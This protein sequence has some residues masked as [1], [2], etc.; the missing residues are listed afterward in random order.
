[1]RVLVDTSVWVDFFNGYPSQ[2]AETLA[3]L[4]RD[5]EDIVT[6][7]LV[8]A[9]LLQGFRDES[10]VRRVR[11]HLLDMDWLS[12]T[13]PGTYFAAAELYRALRQTGVTIRSTVDCIITCLAAE[14]G[15]QVLA[16]DRDFD[17]ILASPHCTAE[18]FRLS[19]HED[20]K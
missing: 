19:K 6:C 9:E 18:A 10:N 14:Q 13:E 4:L 5:E 1:M 17:G 11:R 7:G 8:A 20:K 3:S 12:P 2:E 15:C 16:R